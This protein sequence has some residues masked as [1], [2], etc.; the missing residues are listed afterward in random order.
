M[1]SSIRDNEMFFEM[2]SFS[3]SRMTLVVK[4]PFPMK[5]NSTNRIKVDYFIRIGNMYASISL[6]VDERKH[7]N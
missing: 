5:R 3:A 4:S 6:N 2:V 1:N 7:F